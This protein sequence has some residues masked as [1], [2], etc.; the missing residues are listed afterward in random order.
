M[1]FFSLHSTRAGYARIR[2]RTTRIIRYASASNT[3]G[4]AD[5]ETNITTQITK[6]ECG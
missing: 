2:L 3:S 6:E 1:R 4:S 5:W